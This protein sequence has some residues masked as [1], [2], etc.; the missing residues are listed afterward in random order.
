MHCEYA[1]LFSDRNESNMVYASSMIPIPDSRNLDPSI[2]EAWCM[3]RTFDHDQSKSG[4]SSLVHAP[5]TRFSVSRQAGPSQ[6]CT[7]SVHSPP[8]FHP[9]KR[10]HRAASNLIARP[11]RSSPQSISITFA[12]GLIYRT[13]EIFAE[14]IRVVPDPENDW[15]VA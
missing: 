8:R 14:K 7:S 5:E 11:P 13:R 15:F 4:R 1:S 9:I 12:S 6:H 2:H 10:N 3:R